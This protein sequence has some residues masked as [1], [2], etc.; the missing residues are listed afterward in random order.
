MFKFGK[1][2]EL[3]FCLAGRTKTNVVLDEHKCFILRHYFFFNSMNNKNTL[4]LASLMSQAYKQEKKKHRFM[5]YSGALEK[6]RGKLLLSGKKEN[7]EERIPLK[8]LIGLK[9]RGTNDCKPQKLKTFIFRC[10]G[11]SSMSPHFKYNYI[12]EIDFLFLWLFKGTLMLYITEYMH[13]T[14]IMWNTI[15]FNGS[16]CSMVTMSLTE[17]VKLIGLYTVLNYTCTPPPPDQ[18]ALSHTSVP[19]PYTQCDPAPLVSWGHRRKLCSCS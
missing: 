3:V 14:F 19:E 6:S 11:T 10:A 7:R 16:L 17:A 8:S 12:E 2:K 13:S 15:N 5:L 9:W 18:H 1:S 4:L